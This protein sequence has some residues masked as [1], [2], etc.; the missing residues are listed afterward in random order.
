LRV[1]KRDNLPT[2]GATPSTL[3]AQ[4]ES[5]LDVTPQCLLTERIEALR[6][7]TL[8]NHD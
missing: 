2:L 7:E 8:D 3:G 1:D 6:K 5:L 4:A